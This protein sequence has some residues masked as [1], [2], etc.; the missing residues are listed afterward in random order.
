[1]SKHIAIDRQEY[2]LKIGRQLA[3][4]RDIAFANP[5][6]RCRTAMAKYAAAMDRALTQIL[7]WSFRHARD[8][9]TGYWDDTFA[10]VAVVA[11]GGYGR[12][13][14]APYSDIDVAVVVP[15]SRDAL[16]QTAI[17]HAY[18]IINDALHRG[19]G[20][21]Y[22]YAYYPLDEPLELDERTLSALL[23]SRLVAG[24]P[25]LLRQL[26]GE[27]FRQLRGP[28][29]LQWNAETR[30]LAREQAGGVVHVQE[31][32][33]K[34]SPGGLRDLQCALWSASAVWRRKPAQIIEF[35]VERKKLTSDHAEKAREAEE[36]LWNVRSRLHMLS[37]RKR[38][39][40]SLDVHD[41]I[42][43]ALGY[44]CDENVPDAA[45][46]MK[47]YYA[48]AE[49]I[50]Q[51]SHEILDLCETARISLGD[52]YYVQGRNLHTRNARRVQTSAAA[53]MQGLQLALQYRADLS[54]SLLHTL[55]RSTSAVSTQTNS[56]AAAVLFLGI[57]KHGPSCIR[58]LRAAQATGV[59]QAYIPEFAEAMRTT[60][61]E[62]LHQFTVG[63]HLLRTVERMGVLIEG[64]VAEFEHHAEIYREL[65][66]PE[67]LVLAALLHD[68]GRIEPTRDHCEVG[69]EIA[70]QVAKRLDMPQADAQEVSFL[71]RKHLLL[72]RAATL[73]D[74]RDEVTLHH[75]AQEVGRVETLK[76]LYLLTCADIMAVGPGLW[77]DVRRDQL[78]DL[79][80]RVL[81]HLLEEAP[82]P[83]ARKDIARLRERTIEALLQGG[84][85]PTEAV[86]RHCRLMPDDY[87]LSTDPGMIGVHISLIQ[88][89]AEAPT[90]IDVYTAEGSRYTELTVVRHDDAL[91]GLFSRLCAALYA[92]DVDI[93]TAN[94]YTRLGEHAIVVDSLWVSWQGQPLPSRR[95][96]AI[97]ADLREVLDGGVHPEE[98]L[99]RKKRPRPTSLDIYRIESHNDW[100]DR[101]TGFEIA[102]RDQIGFLYCVTAALAQLGLNIVSAKV[103][104]RGT[105]A[106]DA[107]YVT[108]A[109]G[110]KLTDHE[111]ETIKSR[112]IELLT[113][114]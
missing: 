98:L 107:F 63:E 82:T 50:E 31:P 80:F 65:D 52:G 29:F 48:H 78:E 114:T 24:S 2:A 40:L 74:V 75:V 37:R 42:A 46:F 97:C 61:G 12:R 23:D 103:T 45:L 102:G 111:A 15:H 62:Q 67:I 60:P 28:L 90:I 16:V 89:L 33:I 106:E 77:T 3:A 9:L 64:S 10:N 92:N 91:P 56:P 54:P 57:L 53:V 70:L 113:V 5:R 68:I 110:A 43:A 36:F 96:E 34:Q 99:A 104:T 39:V 30:R 25:N 26:D 76:R 100:S 8:D 84:R 27:V 83:R 88:R 55:T 79:Y 94:I 17:T 93:H 18:H 19:L 44:Q 86:V 112:L 95:A 22:G 35:L 58:V 66:R 109:A 14:L 41:E 38:D 69:E 11:V 108:N 47:E 72:E 1:M 32:D 7:R 101:T 71:V 105:V 85:L 51:V 20:V 73:R 4:A 21:E 49:R 6:R 59:L 81:A 13:T 87:I